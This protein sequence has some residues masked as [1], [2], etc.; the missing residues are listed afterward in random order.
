MYLQ[1]RARH[2]GTALG[3][4]HTVTGRGQEQ[5]QGAGTAALGVA[6]RSPKQLHWL[7]WECPLSAF[8]CPA[9]ATPPRAHTPRARGPQPV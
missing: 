7:R 6:E 8:A 9:L 4:E 5:L 1:D 2:L 3:R